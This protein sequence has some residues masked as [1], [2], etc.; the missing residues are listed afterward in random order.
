MLALSTS[1][2]TTIDGDG[3]IGTDPVNI[4]A[5]PKNTSGPSDHLEI[6]ILVDLGIVI[7]SIWQIVRGTTLG[8]CYSL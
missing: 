3:V 6:K 7:T 8:H 2:P 4:D 1:V 5:P